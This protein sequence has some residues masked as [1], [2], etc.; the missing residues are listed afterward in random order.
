MQSPL[1]PRL[2]DLDYARTVLFGLGIVLHSAWLLRLQSPA[3]QTVHDVI[4]SFRMPGFFVIA[5]FFS[6]LMLKKYSPR[7]F[8]VRRVRRLCLP[9]ITFVAVDIA[10]DSAN[11][12]TWTDYSPELNRAY[13]ISGHWLEHL[14]FLGTLLSYVVILFAVHEIWQ[15]MERRVASLK[16]TPALFLA[17]IAAISF[18]SAHFERLLPGQPWRSVWL[19]ADQIMFFQYI[20]FFVAGYLLFHH[21]T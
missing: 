21:R 18:G 7:E 11:V 17:G 4:H 16:L 6:A 15:S 5:G 20:G 10:I 3:L 14:W 13:W 2:R 12:Y 19:F 8:L 9:L 1:T